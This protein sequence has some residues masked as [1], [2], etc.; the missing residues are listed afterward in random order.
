MA[1]AKSGINK[2]ALIRGILDKAP[3]TKPSEIVAQLKEKGIEISRAFASV[4]KSNYRRA[5]SGRKVRTT[6]RAYRRARASSNGAS[7]E[8]ITAHYR[9]A[10]T[11]KRNELRVELAH[12]ERRLASL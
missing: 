10:L 2:S 4:T 9:E 6:G 7:L 3:D 5:K 12:I 8:E 1:K 11:A